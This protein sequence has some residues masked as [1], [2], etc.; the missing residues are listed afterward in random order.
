MGSLDVIDDPDIKNILLRFSIN[1]Y[2]V[3]ENN[4]INRRISRAAQP[5]RRRKILILSHDRKTSLNSM[6]IN[7]N[8][9][10]ADKMVRDSWK[11]IIKE[12]K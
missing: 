3:F 10:N 12:L 6:S 7:D 1:G 2:T 5:L 9:P 4:R 8:I 11:S